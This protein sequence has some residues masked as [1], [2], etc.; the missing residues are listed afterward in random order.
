MSYE[1]WKVLNIMLEDLG[2]DIRK[3]ESAGR[4]YKDQDLAF[5]DH[6]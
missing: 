6:R 3:L 1:D 5:H 4:R 2:K